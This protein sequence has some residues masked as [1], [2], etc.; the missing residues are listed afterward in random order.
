MTIET[1]DVFAI[2]ERWEAWFM[3]RKG[4]AVAFNGRAVM[5][6]YVKPR[7]VSKVDQAL[8][9]LQEPLAL[10]GD[11]RAAVEAIANPD[12]AWDQFNRLLMA[13]WAATEGSEEGFAI[14]LAFS[15]KSKKHAEEAVRERWR[16]Y[17]RSP[18]TDLG[19]GTLVW[20]A[21][22]AQPGW[23]PPSRQKPFKANGVHALP[24][25]F[26]KQ[27][28]PIVFP[29]KEKGGRLK[30]TCQNARIGTRG[31]GATC[32]HDAFHERFKI[33]GE[34]MAA[35][36]GELTDEVVQKVRMLIFERYGFDPGTANTRDALIQECL[37]NSFHPIKDYFSALQWDGVRR[38]DTWAIRYLGAPD[39][40]FN[41]AVSR[42]SLVAAARRIRHPGCK[43]DHI[44]VLEGPEGRGK[45]S[46]VEILAG[47][48]NFSDQTLL[49]VD[50]R[51]Q[52]EA[53]SGVWLYEIADLAG[54]SRAE[55]E[56][57]KAF[58]SRTMDRARPAY[59]HKRVD[60]PRTCIFF[61]T[62]ND[63]TYL[64]SQTGNRRFWP[65]VCGRIDLEGVRRDRDQLWAEALA[66]EQQGGALF[67]DE[68]LWGEAAQLQDSR[69]EHDPWD[70]E[71]AGA[72]GIEVEGVKG[73]ERRIMSF[74]LM[75]R[76][77][78]PKDRQSAVAA[79]RVAFAMRRL[80][81]DG[82][83]N[84]KYGEGVCKGYTKSM[85]AAAVAPK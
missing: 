41:R 4:R 39:T 52:Q 29:D 48:E 9:N 33:G 30:A 46:V 50:D 5:P 45:S 69:R 6:A 13:I 78:I 25:G 75:A 31:F 63:A 79:K 26:D 59:G 51:A 36:V 49:N 77:E 67:L 21:R 10:I 65:V 84:F 24:P 2:P 15:A 68:S 17:G 3:D 54:H 74:E 16:H 38:L 57:V 34:V 8:A 72:I 80:G 44:I 56:R 81:W 58:A 60:K 64:Q 12:L 1:A 71:L 7:A 37:L 14:G 19:F 35:W 47:S 55:I 83:K 76:L 61:A 20:E 73:P 11:V 18:P 28:D 82:P 27:D 43:F 62:T 53:L 85:V 32:E 22:E 70:D 23:E 40:A 42:L 66:V